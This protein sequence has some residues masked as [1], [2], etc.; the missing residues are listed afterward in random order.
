[1]GEAGGRRGYILTRILGLR[2]VSSPVWM[3]G[4]QGDILTRNAGLRMVSNS[5]W[6]WEGQGEEGLYTHKNPWFEEGE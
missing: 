2:R 5:V 6:M 3:W 4:G 1:M